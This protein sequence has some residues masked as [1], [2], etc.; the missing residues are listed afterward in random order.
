MCVGV[1]VTIWRIMFDT[2]LFFVTPEMAKAKTL[3]ILSNSMQNMATLFL[4]ITSNQQGSILIWVAH[5]VPPIHLIATI[6][7]LRGF[8]LLLYSC[9]AVKWRTDSF[10]FPVQLRM[11][12]ASKD[13][14]TQAGRFVTF[15]PNNSKFVSVDVNYIVF[16]PPMDWQ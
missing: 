6:D 7:Q 2:L 9:T 11:A 1:Q 3:S 8:T 10:R 12:D 14:W 15:E 16:L 5:Q 13:T 4:Q